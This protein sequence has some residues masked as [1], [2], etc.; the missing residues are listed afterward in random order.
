MIQRREVHKPA[1]MKCDEVRWCSDSC[2]GNACDVAGYEESAV[3]S[4]GGAA[5]NSR[6]SVGSSSRKQQQQSHQR[7]IWISS[8]SFSSSSD[9]SVSDGHCSRILCALQS[10]MAPV[11]SDSVCKSIFCKF[12]LLW[13]VFCVMSVRL[14]NGDERMDKPNESGHY[15]STWAVHVP[16]GPEV[17]NQIAAEHGFI[18]LGKVSD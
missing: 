16:E 11:I 1:N 6:P 12:V 3:T 15:T 18:N 7:N 17:A 8:S 2:D 13:L 14:V 9:R 5:D 4:C 10:M